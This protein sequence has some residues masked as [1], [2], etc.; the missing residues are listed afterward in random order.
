MLERDA[1]ENAWLSDNFPDPARVHVVQDS[2]EMMLV[3]WTPRGGATPYLGQRPQSQFV[4]LATF[5]KDCACAGTGII[6]AR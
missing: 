2:D 6:T 1:I 4:P 5:A 3:S